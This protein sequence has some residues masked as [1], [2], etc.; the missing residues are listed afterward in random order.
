M[1]A[2]TRV[3][4]NA[5]RI[6]KARLL[7]GFG[8]SGARTYTVCGV[9]SGTSCGI[10]LGITRGITSGATCGAARVGTPPVRPAVDEPSSGS[11]L[12]C[13][14]TYSPRSSLSSTQVGPRVI[15]GVDRSLANGARSVTGAVSPVSG[16][17][18]V[19]ST[20]PAGCA[21]PVSAGDCCPGSEVLIPWCSLPNHVEFG[22]LY[23]V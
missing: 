12:Y 5:T 7:R 2:N 23:R 10:R 21:E 14:G 11:S 13:P 16:E 6:P 3:P 15:P 9:A 20:G 8:G 18:T 4:T 19:P 1:T 22:L 17:G